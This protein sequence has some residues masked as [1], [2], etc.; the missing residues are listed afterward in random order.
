M[1]GETCAAPRVGRFLSGL[2]PHVRGNLV[3][4]VVFQEDRGSIP[5]CTGKPSQTDR[6]RGRSG[7]YPRMYGE[8]L[9]GLSSSRK[10]G[11]LSP[12]VRGNPV[13]LIGIAADQG[14]IPACTGKPWRAPWRRRGSTVYPRMYGETAARTIPQRPRKGLSPH[15]RGNRATWTLPVRHDG[16]IPACTGKPRQRPGRRAGMGVY[17]RMYG[18]TNH[19][20]NAAVLVWGLSAGA[21]AQRTIRVYPRMYGETS[22]RPNGWRV[23]GGLSPHVRGNH[24]RRTA[25]CSAPGSI[26]ACTGKPGSPRAGRNGSEV[27][28]RMYGETGKDAKV[29]QL[30]DGLSPHVRGNQAVDGLPAIE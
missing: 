4:A 22:T 19:N 7:V 16:S 9:S 12:H 24:G 6:Y 28:P 8:T 21:R 5:A 11:G 17:P 3:R 27:Y 10:T 26:P 30:E 2:S 1:Y 23:C 15:V 25:P 13:K 18:E 20:Q 29:R 14:S